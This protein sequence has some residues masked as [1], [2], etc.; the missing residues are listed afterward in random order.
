[1]GASVSCSHVFSCV[2]GVRITHYTVLDI[3]HPTIHPLFLHPVPCANYSRAPL[4]FKPPTTPY[5]DTPEWIVFCASTYLRGF[6]VDIICV[7]TSCF[8]GNLL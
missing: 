4:P 7:L 5:G 8:K 3:L 6:L 1:M 2:E